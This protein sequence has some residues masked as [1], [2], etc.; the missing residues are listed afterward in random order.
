MSTIQI[1]TESIIISTIYVDSDDF[2]GDITIAT[3]QSLIDDGLGP[4]EIDSQP[5]ITAD[6]VVHVED[7]TETDKAWDR[8]VAKPQA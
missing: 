1:T 3:A 6:R 4:D 2:E 5:H 8:L 7:T